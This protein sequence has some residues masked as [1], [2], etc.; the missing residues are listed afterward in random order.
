MA[1]VPNPGGHP[2]CID[3]TE[4]T[5]AAYIGFINAN[6]DVN[7][8]R[9]ECLPP[10][11]SNFIPQGVSWPWDAAD[12]QPANGVTWCDADAYCTW[13][14]KHLCG[15]MGGG[16]NPVALKNDA[17]SS[18]WYNACSANGN[19]SYP[20]GTSGDDMKCAGPNGMLGAVPTST[21]VGGFVG[22]YDM[23]G[24]VAEWEDSCD[25][26]TD[27]CLVRGGSYAATSTTDMRCSTAAPFARTLYHSPDV[28]FRCCL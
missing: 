2:Y 28:G 13:S 25:P 27:E 5:R 11:N 19:N 9:V 14:G 24:S 15:A 21:C 3:S 4:V 18:E 6:Y 10:S 8:Q 12:A 1:F 17:A 7:Q 23:S 16:G 26:G 22:I 20:Y